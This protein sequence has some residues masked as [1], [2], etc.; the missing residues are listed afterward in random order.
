MDR[1]M[2]PNVPSRN[3]VEEQTIHKLSGATTH[4]LGTKCSESFEI[5][6][7]DA[8]VHVRDVFLSNLSSSVI[9][10]CSDLLP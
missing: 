7:A 10:A 6:D 2:F 4:F 3:S 5:S 8:G 1:M 9:P